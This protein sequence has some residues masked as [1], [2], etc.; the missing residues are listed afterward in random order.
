MYLVRKVSWAFVIVLRELTLTVS[1]ILWNV[2]LILIYLNALGGVCVVTDIRE[3]L[4]ICLGTLFVP[5][6]V[7]SYTVY[8]KRF[9]PSRP[10]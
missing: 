5:P 8:L 1:F 4:R 6:E 3:L 9:H 10:Q 7:L 2:P